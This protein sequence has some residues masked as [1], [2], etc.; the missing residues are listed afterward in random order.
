MTIPIEQLGERLTKALETQHQNESS[1]ILPELI[2]TRPC[3]YSAR[4]AEHSRL[5]AKMRSI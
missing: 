3:L 5:S 2:K 4:A 1:Q